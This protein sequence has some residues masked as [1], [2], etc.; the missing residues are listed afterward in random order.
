MRDAENGARLDVR[1]IE[2]ISTI[3][4]KHIQKIIIN[5]PELL[6]YASPMHGD[7]WTGLDGVLVELMERSEILQASR[8]WKWFSEVLRVPRGRGSTR[9]QVTYLPRFAAEKGQMTIWSLQNELVYSSDPGWKPPEAEMT[10][11]LEEC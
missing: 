6:L 2:C 1:G 11:D 10:A 9:E 5:R 3:N 7:T 4:S 8:G